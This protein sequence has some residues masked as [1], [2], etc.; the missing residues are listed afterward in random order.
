MAS[1]TRYDLSYSFADFQT[2][3]PSIPLPADKLEIEFNNLTL[4]TDEIITNLDL[5]QR[6]DGALKNQIVSFDSLSNDV[7]V[8]LGS[9]ITPKGA[10][11]TATAYVQ[12]D[13]VTESGSTY[14]ATSDHTSGTF[15]TDLAAGKW[16]LWAAS[17]SVTINNSNWSGTDLAVANGGTGVSTLTGLVKGNGTSAFTA[18]VQGTDYYKPGGTDVALADGGT[19]SSTAVGARTNLGLGGLAV[20]STVNND[21]WSGTDLSVANGGTGASDAAG[22]R[23]ALDVYSKGEADA[24]F[25]AVESRPLL[26]TYTISS[27]VASI[28]ITSIL[29][30]TYDTYEIELNNVTIATDARD[31]CVRTSVDNG[32]AWDSGAAHYSWG[33]GYAIDTGV[34]TSNGGDTSDGAIHLNNSQGN[35]ANEDMNG[36]ITIR[37][38]N[39]TTA[40]KAMNWLG[41]YTSAAGNGYVMTG[42]GRRL[43]TSAINALQIIPLTS[44]NTAGG[45][46]TGGVVRIY[47]V[48][49]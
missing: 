46:I 31:L 41:S 38:V 28:D 42:F 39:S 7:K 9:A 25:I 33:I 45:N 29:S 8:L 6:S 22:A 4:T 3:N 37:N 24:L 5:I 32:S 44:T 21:N 16:I 30:S 12:L 27:P 15:A 14:L 13:L 26:A 1:P 11:L 49:K 48:R 10:W 36:L 18:A 34:G 20:L 19:G 35:A 40:Q 23:T 2:A 43:S 17:N 47:G